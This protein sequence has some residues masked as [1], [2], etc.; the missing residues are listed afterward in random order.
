MRV[1]RAFRSL[2]TTQLH[3]R[4]VYFYSEEHVRGHVFLCL[5]AYYVEWHL[6]RKLAPLLFEDAEREAAAA[7][8]ESPVE[9]AQVSRAA[10]AKADTKRT[11]DGLLVQNLQTL[12]DHLGSLTLNQVTLPQDAQ[13]EFQVLSK[14]TPLQAQA[15]A[16]L[17]VDPD[18]FV[19]STV[20][21]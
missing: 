4:P 8:R 18:K 19:S 13:H 15:F 17:E 5:L 7:R 14:P 10:E 3:L 11:P 6:R 1:E 21:A 20:A 12:L 2:K 16:L 9:P